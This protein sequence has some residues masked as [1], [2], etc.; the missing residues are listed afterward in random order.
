MDKKS[1][2]QFFI[3][4]MGSILDIYGTYPYRK[5]TFRL[6]SDKKRKMLA[7][8]SGFERDYESLLL[9]WEKVTYENSEILELN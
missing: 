7:N 4:G 6:Q 3:E 8:K 2:I 1:K 5:N 9:D